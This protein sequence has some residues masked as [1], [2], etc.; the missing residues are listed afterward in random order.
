MHY[1]IAKLSFFVFKRSIYLR[2]TVKLPASGEREIELLA[3]SAGPGAAG[4]N[5]ADGNEI[6]QAADARVPLQS[7]ST[8]KFISQKI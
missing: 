4:V 6:E 1:F 8:K 2:D 7:K 5:S 3:L